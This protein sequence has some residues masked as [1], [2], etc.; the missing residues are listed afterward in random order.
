MIAKLRKRHF[1]LWAV[2][3]LIL[4]ILIILAYTNV[5]EIETDDFELAQPAAFSDVIAN[6]QGEYTL[7]NLR[8]QGTEYQLE[9]VISKPI[10]AANTMVQMKSEKGD[11]ILGRLGSKGLY[12]FAIPEG[13]VISDELQISIFDQIKKME[14]EKINISL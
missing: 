8:K 11:I 14:I 2:I 6:S 1:Q 4:P 9:A 3:A 13:V 12:R 5:R 10:Q 7:L